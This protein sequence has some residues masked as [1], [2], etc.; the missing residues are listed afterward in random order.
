MTEN[1]GSVTIAYYGAAA[2]RLVTASGRKI[3]ID[4][5]LT[6]NPQCQEKLESFYDA[7][8]II[9]SH[10]AAD[11][12]GD[13]VALLENSRAKL[14]CGA[15][16]GKYVHDQGI[17]WERIGVTLYG[18]ER[19]YD[20]IQIKTVFA[21]HI[22]RIE[23]KDRNYYG[24]PLAYVITTEDG[25]RIFH[26]GDTALF[27]D[28]QLIGRLHHPHI[29]M[30]GIGSFA[31][32]LPT[33]MNAS[34]AAMAALWVAPDVVIPMHYAP[35]AAAP[36]RFLEAVRIIAPR[37]QPVMLEPNREFVYRKFQVCYDK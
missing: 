32:G 20:G 22:S 23:T 29:F 9:V 30:V 19:E 26:P 37:V 27:G 11:H 36:Q 7:E 33:E 5:C 15:D 12:L 31:E 4:P 17:P 14:V 21:Q 18:D 6:E 25:I 13:T 8:L 35:G 2:F 34:E 10:G 24:I 3:L 28:L 16:V 1:G